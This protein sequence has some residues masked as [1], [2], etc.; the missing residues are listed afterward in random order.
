MAAIHGY[1]HPQWPQTVRELFIAFIILKWCESAYA[2]AMS[3][4]PPD[5]APHK[6]KK[7]NEKINKLNMM[8][9]RTRPTEPARCVFVSQPNRSYHNIRLWQLLVLLLLW[10]LLWMR[11]GCLSNVDIVGVG[12]A[13]C[14][15][16][17]AL[18]YVYARVR[19]VL[20]CGLRWPDGRTG[21]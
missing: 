13:H 1:G 14:M 6:K 16:C 2:M 11:G 3:G 8:A 17:N 18:H 19:S 20:L 7:R 15:Q 10:L 12:M 9:R 4:S 5:P 21:G